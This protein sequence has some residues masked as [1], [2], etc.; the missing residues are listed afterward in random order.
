MYL[1]IVRL[2]TAAK[3]TKIADAT[4]TEFEQRYENASDFPAV[5]VKLAA[6]FAAEKQPAKEREI[7]QKVLDYLGKQ[8]KPLVPPTKIEFNF[9][10]ESDSPKPIAA[11][12]ENDGINIPSE[13]TKPKENDFYDEEQSENFH[14]YLSRDGQEI[15]YAD[16][17]DRFVNSL[18]K[19]KQTAEVLELYS[20]EIRKYPNEG[21]LYNCRLTWLEQTNLA[22]EEL[23]VYQQALIRFQTNE[24]ADG[25]RRIFREFNRQAERRGRGKLP[26]AIC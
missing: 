16:V 4:L 11:P 15:F 18:A 24:S 9:S 10:T 2:Y 1:D 13:K 7:Y 25:L 17:L 19:E 3:K 20:N 5:A 22:E 26:R 12:N 21:W 6:A 8:N 23:K 14:D